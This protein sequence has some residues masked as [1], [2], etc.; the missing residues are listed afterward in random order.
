MGLQRY[1]FSLINPNIFQLFFDFL[2]HTNAHKGHMSK[3]RR[4][5][6]SNLPSSVVFRILVVASGYA[7]IA[8]RMSADRAYFRS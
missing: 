2:V 1:V 6:V 5:V 8:L 7:E 3:K 4:Q